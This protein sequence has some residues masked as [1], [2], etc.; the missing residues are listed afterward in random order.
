MFLFV[1]KA[2]LCK[3]PQGLFFHHEAA[4]MYKT[5]KEINIYTSVI[6]ENTVLGK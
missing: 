1:I 2:E 6:I 4:Q 3:I 5:Q